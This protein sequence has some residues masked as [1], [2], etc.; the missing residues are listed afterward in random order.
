MTAPLSR[1]E[2]EDVWLKLHANG[3]R[4]YTQDELTEILGAELTERLRETTRIMRA[5]VN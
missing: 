3:D 4:S 1:E 5:P 2:L